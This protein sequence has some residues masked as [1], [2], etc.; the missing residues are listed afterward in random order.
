M[1]NPDLYPDDEELDRNYDAFKA[2]LPELMKK[3]KGRWAIV[4]EEK[5]VDIYDKFE[6]ASSAGLKQYGDHRFNLQ[7]V[8]DEPL[9]FGIFSHV[10]D[11]GRS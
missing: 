9:Y 6:E 7:E 4:R 8:T 5:V 11:F 2:V 10:A 1:S 3:H